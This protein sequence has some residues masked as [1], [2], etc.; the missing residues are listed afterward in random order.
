MERKKLTMLDMA[1]LIAVPHATCSQRLAILKC[2]PRVQQLFG[3]N[4]LPLNAASILAR[5]DSAEKQ[6]NYAGMLARRTMTVQQ[7]KEAI[8]E[9]PHARRVHEKTAAST[10]PRPGKT[11]HESSAPV[12]TRALAEE[13]LLKIPA[14]KITM[15]TFRAALETVCCACGMKNQTE[16]CVNC[17]LPRLVMAVV[18][19]SGY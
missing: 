14:K 15:H 2:E 18:G 11:H 12:I 10:I 9:D 1:R 6:V 8:N 19:R 17:P 7:L 3:K 4:E 5:V 16:V 13:A